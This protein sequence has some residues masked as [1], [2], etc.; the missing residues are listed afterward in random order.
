MFPFL[1][2]WL[3]DDSRSEAAWGSLSATPLL[4]LNLHSLYY[5]CLCVCNRLEGLP[6]FFKIKRSVGTI[7]GVIQFLPSLFLLL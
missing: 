4:L 1:L 2:V 5:L 3:F 7:E 6:S